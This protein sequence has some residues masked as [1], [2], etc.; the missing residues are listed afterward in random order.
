MKQYL[1]LLF[2][3][4]FCFACKKGEITDVRLLSGGKNGTVF[5]KSQNAFGHQM[6][7]MSGE[8]ELLFFVGNS[9]FNQNWVEAP[10]SAKARDGLGPLFNARSCTSCHF[11]DGRGEPIVENGQVANGFLIRLSVDGTDEHGGPVSHQ[12]YGGQ[13]N[14]LSVGSVNPEG[15]IE[16]SFEYINGTYD[17]GIP[18]ELRKPIYSLTDLNYGPMGLVRMSPRVGQQ[19]IGLGLLEAL[20]ED[21]ITS[22][23]DEFD[24]DGDGISGKP[25][26][27]WDIASQSFKVGIFGWKAEQPSLTQQVASAFLGDLGIKS[28]L[29]PNENHTSNQPQC[30]DLPDGGD[31]EVENDDL[32]KTVIYASSLAVPARRDVDDLDIFQGENIFKGIGCAGCHIPF[33]NY[34]FGSRVYIFK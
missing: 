13:F 8:S 27:V 15:N 20:G 3:V 19:M 16:V 30:F 14:D 22:L 17:D 4:T 26:Y 28:N 33:F 7:G 32:R 6:P 21:V 11:K 34:R 1:P 18:Y 24:S 10:A 2:L 12:I 5:D 25:N 31:I 23:S 9:F 29:F